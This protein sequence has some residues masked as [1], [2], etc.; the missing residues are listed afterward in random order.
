MKENLKQIGRNHEAI[1]ISKCA[2]EDSHYEEAKELLASL[3]CRRTSQKFASLQKI[4]V[5]Q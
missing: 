5:V 3:D 4:G 1:G 2:E